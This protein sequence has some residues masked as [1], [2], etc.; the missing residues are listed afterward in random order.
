MQMYLCSCVKKIRYLS[1]IT[2]NGKKLSLRK[3]GSE[4]D[5]NVQNGVAKKNLLS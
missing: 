4:K 2:L 1:F 5:L 3:L